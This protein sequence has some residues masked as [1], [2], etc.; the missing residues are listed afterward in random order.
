[1]ARGHSM[2][3]YGTRS[4]LIDALSTVESRHD[5]AYVP[6]GLFESPDVEAIGAVRQIPG[7][8]LPP[9]CANVA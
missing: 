7:F 2:E 9:P 4:D 5:L 1:M 3:L 8:A 6:C